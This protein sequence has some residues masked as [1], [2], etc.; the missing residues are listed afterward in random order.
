MYPPL[1]NSSRPST[2]HSGYPKL[3]VTPCGYAQFVKLPRYGICGKEAAQ[4]ERPVTEIW[5][6]VAV[7]CTS[8]LETS[9]W[10]CNHSG[11]NLGEEQ[12]STHRSV[13]S[14]HRLF[15]QHGSVQRQARLQPR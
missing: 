2:A 4:D 3:L 1:I 7:R 10:G 12:G 15:G 6:L 14:P 5:T 8:I 9:R 13:T 11:W